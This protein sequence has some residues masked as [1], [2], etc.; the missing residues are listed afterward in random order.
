MPANRGAAACGK[1]EQQKTSPNFCHLIAEIEARLVLATTW[2]RDRDLNPG[3]PPYH[4]G[5]LPLSYHGS[6]QPAR[7]PRFAALAKASA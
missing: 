1:E 4:G 3:P 2:S 7:L 5:A 6:S